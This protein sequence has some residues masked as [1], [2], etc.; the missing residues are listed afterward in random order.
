MHRFTHMSRSQMASLHR[1]KRL[2]LLGLLLL[3]L[4]AVLW[5]SPKS[6]HA[7]EDMGVLHSFSAL[8]NG[9]NGDGAFPVGG[10]VQANNGLFYGVA[11]SGGTN[12]TG[13]VFA[14]S[15]SGSFLTLYNFS[16]LDG[17]GHNTDGA[18]PKATLIQGKNGNLYG[19][20]TAGGTNG[21]GT[22]FQLTLSG[23]LTTLHSFGALSNGTNSDGA[24]PNGLVQAKNSDLLGTAPL[25][26]S[27]GTGTIFQIRPN[28]NGQFV[29]NG[30]PVGTFNTLYNFSAL[31][32]GTNSDGAMPLGALLQAI[33]GFFYGTTYLGGPNGTGTVF[34]VQLDNSGNLKQFMLLHAFTSLSNNNTN[35]D[36]ANPAASLL[37]VCD[38]DLYGTTVNG[39]NGSGVLFRIQPGTGGQFVAGNSFIGTYSV[40]YSFSA[41]DNS[42]H[43]TDGAHPNTAL[44]QGL[45]CGDIYGTTS[46][47]GPNG[48]GTLFRLPL[49]A[50]M[51]FTDLHNFGPLTNGTNT[52]GANPGPPI[53]TP[54]GGFI[55]PVSHG[56]PNGTGALDTG[57]VGPLLP[58]QGNPLPFPAQPPKPI[59]PLHFHVPPGWP[60]PPANDLQVNWRRGPNIFPVQV[61]VQGNDIIVPV[62]DG[63]FNGGPGCV[64][65]QINNILFNAGP[66]F[67]FN[68][69]FPNLVGQPEARGAAAC[70]VAGRTLLVDFQ[71]A[72]IGTAQANAVTITSITLL[73]A[74][75]RPVSNPNRPAG[76]ALIGNIA[77]G[78]VESTIPP[79]PGP[80]ALT[81]PGGRNWRGN[82]CGDRRGSFF[83]RVTGTY[84]NPLFPGKTLPF[85]V[86][87][88]Y[89]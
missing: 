82:L 75:G 26:G 14:L 1:R 43:N 72:N 86:L 53:Q 81:L 23:N 30:S 19:T 20:T 78:T 58:P 65:C 28:A 73:D 12:G 32:S 62:P 13:V 55:V 77:A 39:G 60:V 21:N 47:G 31:S 3:V 63:I 9:T 56:G 69:G 80:F 68:I 33:D 51:P 52:D 89:P 59:P 42:G 37:Q 2:C 17:N 40:A 36:G 84:T 66:N 79:G 34:Q 87:I 10:L 15:I 35:S 44:I 38:G 16:A 5:I 18:Y 64:N 8:S 76:G 4:V 83:L 61:Q 46:D 7:Q 22:V 49:P 74:T 67:N 29:V 57:G 24:Q 54:N 27:N 45:D 6:C 11:P 50:G 70:I 88:P 85:T 25:G 48:T 71:I 41:L